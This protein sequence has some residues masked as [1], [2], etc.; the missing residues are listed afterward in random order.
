MELTHVKKIVDDEIPVREKNTFS[1]NEAKVWFEKNKPEHLLLKS[2]NSKENG[3]IVIPDWTDAFSSGKNEIEVVEC[4]V[5]TDGGFGF[6]TKETYN[7]W[8]ETQNDNYLTSLTRLVVL[9]HKK[10]R[11]TISF[12]MTIVGDKKYLEKKE[13]NI[14][15][16]TYFTKDKAFNGLILYHSNKGEFVNGWRFT[17][18]KVSHKIKMNSG[19]DMQIHLKSQL[20]CEAHEIFSWEIRCTDYYTVGVIDEEYDMENARYSH[21]D[22]ESVQV[23]GGWDLECV[24]TGNSGGGDGGGGTSGGYNPAPF[25]PASLFFQEIQR[26]NLESPTLLQDISCLLRDLKFSGGNMLITNTFE[27]AGDYFLQG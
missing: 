9:R 11:E 4:G 5:L 14:L 3:K 27:G 10:T 22:C 23:S 18:G 25:T 12:L 20:V 7:K 26:I 17:N 19:N 16:D 24:V 15:D 8:C 2:G 13:F 1:V 6:A 21:T